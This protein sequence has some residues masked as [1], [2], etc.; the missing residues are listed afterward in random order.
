MPPKLTLPVRVS[1]SSPLMLIIFPG[2]A[3]HI[4]VCSSVRASRLIFDGCGGLL[5]GRDSAVVVRDA[6]MAVRAEAFGAQA[7]NGVVGKVA[8]LETAARHEVPLFAN[9]PVHGDDHP[10]PL[11][12]D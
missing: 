6:L 9:A 10:S 3:R 1:G 5:A 2:T 12:A 4:I 11:A 8:I 7:L